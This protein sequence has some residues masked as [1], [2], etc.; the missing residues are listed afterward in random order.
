[1][2]D[3]R[4]IVGLRVWYSTQEEGI[5]VR[6]VPPSQLSTPSDLFTTWISLP[7]DGVQ[8]V[9]VYLE[10]TYPIWRGGV[11]VEE[12]YRTLYTG[13]DY[14]YCTPEGKIGA[15]Q[16]SE[17][18]RGLPLVPGLVKCGSLLSDDAWAALSALVA[19]ER[20]APEG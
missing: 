18:P 16:A 5:F 14:Y 4:Q 11:Q 20:V 7:D 3:P 2:T 19:E 6:E 15:G 10:E 1:M 13:V 9:A 12:H 17:M 8:A